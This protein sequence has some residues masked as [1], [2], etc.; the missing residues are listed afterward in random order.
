MIDT[1]PILDQHHD[2]LVWPYYP[3]HSLSPGNFWCWWKAF[4]LRPKGRCFVLPL[5]QAVFIWHKTL[6][7]YVISIF[8]HNMS[9]ASYEILLVG[10]NPNFA[11]LQNL[12]LWEILKILLC[13]T[14]TQKLNIS[15]KPLWF[16][17]SKTSHNGM[18]CRLRAHLQNFPNATCLD[19]YIKLILCMC[20]NTIHIKFM[21]W[22]T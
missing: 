11:G 4:W 22:L 1:R 6:S 7:Q 10:V 16:S 14:A 18:F 17:S 3:F 5:N 20:M 21:K 8:S 13:T 15:K 2:C 19:M 9:S 12:P